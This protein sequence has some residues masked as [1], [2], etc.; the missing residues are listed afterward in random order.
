VF[1]ASLNQTGPIHEWKGPAVTRSHTSS[2]FIRV[3]PV[4]EYGMSSR[5]VASNAQSLDAEG[6][7]AQAI[8]RCEPPSVQ[9]GAG[10][11]FFNGAEQ[12]S[13]RNP[14]EQACCSAVRDGPL[15]RDEITAVRDKKRS[16]SACFSV[17]AKKKARLTIAGPS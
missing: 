1:C 14:L 7:S 13:V 11:R 5:R 9:A 10:A 4:M 12:D 8:S 17:A 16:H 3:K 2:T 6:S 15:S